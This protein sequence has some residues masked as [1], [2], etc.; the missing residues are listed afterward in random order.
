MLLTGAVIVI[1]VVG[2]AIIGTY[3]Y[4]N[5]QNAITQ[6]KNQNESRQAILD[7]WHFIL[8]YELADDA[9]NPAEVTMSEMILP[10]FDQVYAQRD[11]SDLSK[12]YNI[13][14]VPTIPIQKEQGPNGSHFQ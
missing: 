10:W 12:R 5:K 8:G 1:F 3:A 13:P 9:N 6:C 11:C 4:E 2:G 14:P 7:G